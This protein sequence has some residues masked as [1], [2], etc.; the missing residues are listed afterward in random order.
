MMTFVR[1]LLY[2]S[3]PLEPTVFT[4]IEETESVQ[5]VRLLL[6]G[7]WGFVYRI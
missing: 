7:R 3:C 5:R 2:A 4:V 6:H 1:Y